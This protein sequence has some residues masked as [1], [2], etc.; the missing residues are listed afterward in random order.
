MPTAK[1]TAIATFREPEPAARALDAYAALGNWRDLRVERE[2][3]PSDGGQQAAVY[4]LYGNGPYGQP[5][6]R[7]GKK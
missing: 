5:R 1:G 7:Q 3:A 4:T 2:L 6:R